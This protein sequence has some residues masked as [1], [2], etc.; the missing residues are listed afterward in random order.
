MHV[1]RSSLVL[2]VSIYV[3]HARQ[4]HPSL[5]IDVSNYISPRTLKHSS[6]CM[7]VSNYIFHVAKNTS[8]VLDVSIDIFHTR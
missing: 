5:S 2:E 8:F 7:K 6:M 1:I 3:F 4:K